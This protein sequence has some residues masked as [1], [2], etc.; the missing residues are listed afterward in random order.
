MGTVIIYQTSDRRVCSIQSAGSPSMPGPDRAPTDYG[1]NP[2]EY[3]CW[4][5]PTSFFQALRPE[6]L[7]K[8]GTMARVVLKDKQPVGIQVL[9]VTE[10]TALRK[11]QELELLKQSL[12][13]LFMQL[14]V[15]NEFHQ[16][17]GDEID[18]V[19]DIE[20][21]VGQF[22]RAKDRYKAVVDGAKVE[23]DELLLEVA[24]KVFVA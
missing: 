8:V 7:H 20:Q 17:H 16:V 6:M 15:L 13:S 24:N 22:E 19:A 21:C 11:G 4:N 2:G 12:L 14:K 3:A 18:V 5:V 9:P 1:L 23:V 10:I